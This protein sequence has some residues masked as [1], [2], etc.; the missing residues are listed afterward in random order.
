MAAPAHVP[1]L[2]RLGRHKPRAT[3]RWNN[4]FY[5]T[6]CAR[7]GQDLVRT[8]FGRW[9]VPRGYRIVWQAFAP[10]NAA[11]AELVRAGE[12]PD[13][14]GA[15]ELPIQEVLR[16]VQNGDRSGDA[17]DGGP[18]A[19]GAAADAVATA[20]QPACEP[21]ADHGDAGG[22]S[23]FAQ[24]DA[25]ARTV[26]ASRVGDFMDEASADS[27][28]QPPAR[29]YLVRTASPDRA[30]AEPA[31]EPGALGRM[32]A[33]LAALTARAPGA[34]G[35]DEPA[36]AAPRPLFAALAIMLA[37]VL[38]LLAL[39]FWAGQDG[40]GPVAFDNADRGVPIGPNQGEAAFVTASQLNCRDAPAREAE[41]VALMT[42]GDPVRLLERDGEWVSLVYRGGQCWALYRFFSVERPIQGIPS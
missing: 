18:A 24:L 21:P 40:G 36:P 29:R 33:R 30:V 28:W 32:R 26:P 20:G 38:A 39:I 7:C 35:D 4:G 31:A 14:A 17:P 25:M 15:R 8:A 22:E 34:G 16:H 12:A 3:T 19:A 42:R 10:A 23:S 1:L 11:S 2:C 13:S 5:F 27:G 9:Q 6:R 37:L 41:P